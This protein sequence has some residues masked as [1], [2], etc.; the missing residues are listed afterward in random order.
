MGLKGDD[1]I[2]LGRGDRRDFVSGLQMGEDGDMSDQ[3][4]G[5]REGEY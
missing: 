1:R 3:I 2:S 4:V 5:D